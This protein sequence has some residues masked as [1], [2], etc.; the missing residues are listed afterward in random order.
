MIY[1]GEQLQFTMY[2]F[3]VEMFRLFVLRNVLVTSFSVLLVFRME[4]PAATH[5]YMTWHPKSVSQS[6]T[7]RTSQKITV[8]REDAS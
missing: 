5:K 8:H 3:L 7:Q 1:E 4:D 2:M 6:R